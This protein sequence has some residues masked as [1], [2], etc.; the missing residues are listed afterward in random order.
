MYV[1]IT[2]HYPFIVYYYY[3]HFHAIKTITTG[4]TKKTDES[5]DNNCLSR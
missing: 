1:Y 5:S 4:K 2:T 3:I